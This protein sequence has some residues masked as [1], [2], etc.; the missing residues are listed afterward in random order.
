[1]R[2]RWP[3]R[4][5][6]GLAVVAAFVPILGLA[7]WDANNAIEGMKRQR[8]AALASASE[9]AAA[10]YGV[11]VDR[12]KRLVSTVCGDESV[13]RSAEL[14][15]TPPEVTACG[16]LL[17]RAVKTFAPDYSASL[18]TDAK[19]IARC[20]SFPAIVGMTFDDRALFRQVRDTKSI[21]VGAPVAKQGDAAG[22]RSCGA[23]DYARRGIR[24]HMFHRHVPG[25]LG[26]YG[27][28]AAY[29][30]WG[31]CRSGGS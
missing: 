6:L 14:D 20:A 25:Q 28:S 31:G 5:K 11:L 1:M 26:R 22:N 13:A 21:G 4:W 9:L 17:E 15:A 18:V 7:G 8:E 29:G 2:A 12:T 10:R 24:R 3:L 16:I 19:G 30:W 27:F 23:T